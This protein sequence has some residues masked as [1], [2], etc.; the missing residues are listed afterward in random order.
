MYKRQE[1]LQS[2]PTDLAAAGPV[3]FAKQLVEAATLNQDQR[4]PVALIAKDM[5]MAWEKQGK[6]RQ[7]NP[8]GRILRMLLIGGGGCGK[9]RIVNLV[10]TPLFLQFWGPRGCVKAAPSNKAARGILGKILHVVGKLG[11]GSLN[12]MNLRCG[13]AAL[14]ALAYLWAPGGAF[15]IDEAPQGAAALYHAVALRS[16]YGRVAAHEVELADYAEPSQTFGAMPIVVECGDE[17]QLPPVPAS[18]GLFAEQSRAATEHLAGVEIFKQKDYVYRLS[19]MKRFTDPAQISIL[20]KM[21]RS[22]GC[23]LT[24]QEWEALRDTDISAASATEQRKRLHGTELWYQA[25]PTWATVSMAQ[26]IRSRL[27]AEK[28]A[29]TLFI[30][31]AKDYI[32][33]RPN[34][35]RLTDAYLAE[36]ISSVPNM[37]NTGRLPSIGLFHLGMVIRLTNTVEAPEA[38]TDSTGEIVGIDLDPDEPSAATEH[39]SAI[40]GIRILHRLPTIQ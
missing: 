19:T 2:I 7:M 38:V 30:V 32:L 35:A 12:M 39:T 33:N 4:T 24:T 21:R 1:L 11:G 6:P 8:V 23:K 15:I 9:S 36:V 25:A 3:A 17:L 10:L 26:V 40:E 22:G 27:S 16:C 37:N 5:Q 28:A 29:A 31:P 34:N 13:A 20:T 14:K 18:A